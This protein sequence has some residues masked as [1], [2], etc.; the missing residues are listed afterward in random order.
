VGKENKT[1]LLALLLA[2]LILAP[3]CKANMVATNSEPPK[4]TSSRD[5]G[6][7]SAIRNMTS[8]RSSH[9]ATLLKN[10]RVLIAGGFVGEEQS[11]S[12]AE[13]YDPVTDSFFPTESMSV[14]R[15]S[16]TAT[17]L[18]NGKVLIAGGM[19]NGEYLPSAEL[20]DPATGR[21]TPT[22]RMVMARS[23]HTAT[24]L[25]N[26]KV[27]LA[28]GT[29]TGWTF[30]ANAEL[31]DTA[32]NTFIPTG[33]MAT[34]R[35]S[36][37]AT[38]LKNGKV[39]ITGGHQGRRS[40]ITIYN[41]AEIYDSSTGTFTA[42]GNL[43]VKR[44]KHDAT[45]LADGQVLITGGSDE[46]DG[47]GAY[48]SAEIYNP[49]TDTFTAISN[50]NVT[51]YKHQGTSVLLNNGKVLIAG[52]ADRAEVYDPATRSFSLAEGSMGTKRLFSTATL[53]PNGQVL[54]AGGYGQNI[55]ASASAW[56]YK[57]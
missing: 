34:A 20:Y 4:V 11:L 29:G 56:I 54:I 12:S 21:F 17:L 45:L 2:I 49:A 46:R 53:L 3:G 9:T 1:S 24:L 33:A 44:H 55:S 42:T 7:V 50:M 39:L 30:L 36:H 52:G 48:R 13:I 14:A 47:D 28:G 8:R 6:M 51:R 27:L 40:S 5:A 18:S 25:N 41:S 23:G 19:D 31:Y 35:E 32:T 26:G 37:I 16:H 10:G 57:T 38:L 43:Q 22:G 15:L